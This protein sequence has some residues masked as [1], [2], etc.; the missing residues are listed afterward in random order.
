MPA[1][2]NR[3]SRNTRV[4]PAIWFEIEAAR[5]LAIIEGIMPSEVGGKKFVTDFK[6][7]IQSEVAKALDEGRAIIREATTDL[8][9]AIKEQ[10]KGAARLIRQEAQHIRDELG[11]YTGNNPPDEELPETDGKPDPTQSKSGEGEG[12]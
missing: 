1:P 2:P 4:P 3:N 12:S 9:D 7:M 10:S 6:S 5:I 11:E 8:K